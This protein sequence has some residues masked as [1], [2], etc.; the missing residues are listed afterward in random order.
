VERRRILVPLAATARSI[1]TEQ[2]IVRKLEEIKIGV[3]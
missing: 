3:S 1:T 2:K